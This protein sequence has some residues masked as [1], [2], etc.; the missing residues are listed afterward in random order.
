MKTNKTTYVSTVQMTPT[1]KLALRKQLLKIYNDNIVYL[2]NGD[3]Y[4]FELYN[5]TTSTYLVKIKIDNNYISYSGIVL[6]PGERIWL[7]R[8]LDDNKKFKFSTYSVSNTEENQKAIKNNGIVVIEFYPEIIRLAP[9]PITWTVQYP[10]YPKYDYYGPVIGGCYPENNQF[11]CSDDYNKNSNV[12]DD[13]HVNYSSNENNGYMNYS[14]NKVKGVTNISANIET[15]RTEKGNTSSQKFQNVN[16]EFSTW[17]TYFYEYKIL[18]Y[19]QKPY[20][21]NKEIYTA[22]CTSC[23]RG[24]KKGENYCPKCGKKN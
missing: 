20:L 8:F 21:T 10:Y 9:N 13:G 19:S 7:E 22:Y 1:A 6:R 24:I 4:E 12:Y 23:G 17:I 3:E 5:P 16:M 2:N 15:G 14:S 18:P 11:Y